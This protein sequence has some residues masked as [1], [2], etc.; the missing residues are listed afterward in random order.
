VIYVAEA[1]KREARGRE[2]SRA[3]GEEDPAGRDDSR[4]AGGPPVGKR[5]MIVSAAGDITAAGK[6]SNLI[7]KI[8]SLHQQI[9]SAKLPHRGA[10]GCGQ[11][12]E[13]GEGSDN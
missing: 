5:S 7:V 2:G 3:A 6:I 13:D 9:G 10:E 11:A 8:R 4:P 12:M 1:D